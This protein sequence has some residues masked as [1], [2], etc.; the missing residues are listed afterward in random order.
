MVNKLGFVAGILSLIVLLIS[1]IPIFP[2]QNI[3]LK[4]YIYSY[5]EIAFYLWG[6][7]LNN[8]EAYSF[9]SSSFPE[10]L[11]SL[12]TWLIF[13]FLTISNILASTKNSN[14]SNS[15][16]IYSLNLILI[17][18]VL[19]IYTLQF[20]FLYLTA[21]G[22]LLSNIGIGYYLMVIILILEI[23]AKKNLKKKE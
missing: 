18:I 14:L 15:I 9:L 7:V 13:C 21:F 17:I 1:E 12:L 22:L 20:V 3:V 4:F 19:V 23:I 11:I 5:D 2:P 16:K 6:Y 10:S 8:S